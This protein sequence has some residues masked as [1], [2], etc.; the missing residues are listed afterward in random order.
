MSRRAKAEPS[1]DTCSIF[2][3]LSH[4]VDSLINNSYLCAMYTANINTVLIVIANELPITSLH[5]LKAF[6]KK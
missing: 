3:R 4:T 5:Q 1:I 6:S 2:F